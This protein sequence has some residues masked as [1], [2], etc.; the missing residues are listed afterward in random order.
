VSL[1][2]ETKS[3]EKYLTGKELVA[4]SN[5]SKTAREGELGTSFRHLL[6]WTIQEEQ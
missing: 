3:I 6:N 4:M 1:G 5:V 2:H